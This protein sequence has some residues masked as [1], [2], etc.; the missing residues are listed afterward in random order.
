L[1]EAKLTA[2]LIAASVERFG[3]GFVA[4]LASAYKRLT[5]SYSGM[6]QHTYARVSEIKTLVN[7][8]EP[9]P[10]I[11]NF[12]SMTMKH[13]TGLGEKKFDEVEFN[14]QISKRGGRYVISALA[15]RGKSILLKYLAL[16][17]YHNPDGRIPLFL[18]LRNLNALSSK[19][20]LALIHATYAKGTGETLDTFKSA[21][22]SGAFILFLDGFDE[23]D[24]ESREVV[25]RQILEAARN[26]PDATV[27]VSGRPDPKFSSWSN[28]LVYDIAPLTKEQVV[29][30]IESLKYDPDAKRKFIRQV[31]AELFDAHEY[32]LTTPL[33]AILMLLTFNKF[34]IIPA[35][36][37]VFYENAFDTLF[38][39]HDA[40][41][42]LY[43]R[44]HRSDLPIDVFKKVLCVLCAATYSRE[45]F[46]FR[47]SELLDQVGMALRYTNVRASAADFA[48][49][50]TE[51]VCILQRDGTEISFTHRS[52]QEFFCALFLAR[53][54]ETVRERFFA[55]RSFR[56][57]DSVLPMLFDMVQEQLEAEW[58]LP[59]INGFL[60]NLKSE[61]DEET[62]YI[63]ATYR[64]LTYALRGSQLWDFYLPRGELG[65]ELACLKKMYP[66][67]FVGA[68]SHEIL[69]NETIGALGRA[70]AEVEREAIAAGDTRFPV[71]T[72][73]ENK[74]NAD[75][76]VPIALNEID[77]RRE[78]RPWL[79]KLGFMKLAA[80]DLK[81][82]RSVKREIEQ[83]SR[84]RIRLFDDFFSGGEE[85]Q[86]R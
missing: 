78:D 32:F 55:E 38:S 10:L 24:Y 84:T 40:T 21:L 18:E 15:G 8:H 47:E 22:A 5:R 74:K 46:Q 35:K 34:A 80:A 57:H 13:R 50:L 65:Y 43:T 39:Q 76:D 71:N 49:D 85:H 61:S 66:A 86:R 14:E 70:L 42:E 69:R 82:I 48:A 36:M 11:D 60:A 67:H 59:F 62:G 9:L 6:L 51:A 45:I 64:T 28:F 68:G 37:H 17:R 29:A 58:V 77:L 83:R 26:Y 53:S 52:F 20:I 63:L 75:P 44:K 2:E 72:S 27:I 23:V 1:D 31:K 33:L 41:K 56:V 54:D 19:D 73:V 3:G 30:L 7:P 79:E 81:A 25:E 4:G 12:I 16:L